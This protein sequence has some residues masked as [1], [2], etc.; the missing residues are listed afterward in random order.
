MP[1][2]PTEPSNQL[3]L[4]IHKQLRA[5]HGAMAL[6]LSLTVERGSCVALLGP[7]GAGKT[8][9]L[10]ILAGLASPDAGRIDAFGQCWLDTGRRFHLP[11]R[12]RHI[13]YVFQDYALFPHMSVRGNVHFALRRDVARDRAD[14][15]LEMAGLSGLADERPDRLSGGQQ[16]RLALVRA[17]ASDPQLLLLDEPLSALDV[18]LRRQ[19]QDA[20]LEIR[21]ARALTTI[22]VTHDPLEAMRLADRAILIEEGSIVEDTTPAALFAHDHSLAPSSTLIGRVIGHESTL[23]GPRCLVECQGRILSV[24]VADAEHRNDRAGTQATALESGAEVTLHAT[25]WIARPKTRD[26]APTTPPDA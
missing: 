24:R 5:A 11:C 14:E 17:L 1:A 4:S 21:R 15:L 3:T 16:Q 26:R 23:S 25:D 18:S 19:L 20:L 22:V 8:T 13:G 2:S 12:K 6:S 9:A 10:R 7:S